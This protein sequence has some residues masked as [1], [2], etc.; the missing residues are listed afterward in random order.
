MTKLKAE[1]ERL[2]HTTDA[3]TRSNKEFDQL[4]RTIKKKQGIVDSALAR[5]YPGSIRNAAIHAT[6]PSFV[7]GYRRTLQ[8]KRKDTLLYSSTPIDI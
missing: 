7:S 2:R 5:Q 1:S 8:R 6:T 4:K 3:L